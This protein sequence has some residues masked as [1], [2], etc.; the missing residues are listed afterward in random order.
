MLDT[1]ELAESEPSI[2]YGIRA[3]AGEARHIHLYDPSRWPPGVLAQ[4]ALDWPRI[5][6]LLR[7]TGFEGSASVVLVPEGDAERAARKTSAFLLSALK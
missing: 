3:G 6:E 1:Y 4:T 5:F 2:E 7:E